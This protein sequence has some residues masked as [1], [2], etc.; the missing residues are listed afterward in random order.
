MAQ[1]LGMIRKLST[2]FFGL[3]I[4]AILIYFN[5]DRWHSFWLGG[6][7]FLVY[8]LVLGTYYRRVLTKF[9]NFLDKT[10]TVFVGAF[11]GLFIFAGLSGV[12][13]V[14][15]RLDAAVIAGA[16]F[17]SGALGSVS[18]EWAERARR[19][20]TEVSDLDDNIAKEQIPNVHF[21]ALVFLVLTAYGF[22]LLAH[23]VTG[24]AIDTPWWAIH[25]YFLYVFI[26]ATLIIG[27][28]VFSQLRAR[29]ILLLLIIYTFLLHSYLP[30]THEL[31]YG[32]DQWR[33]LAAES[34]IVQG[35][36]PGTVSIESADTP[37]FLS[38]TPGSLFYSQ[39][40]GL[41]VALGQVLQVDLIT[42]AK[43]LLPII[44][45]IIFP[46]LV[47][48]IGL[49][50]FLHKKLVLFLIWLTALP[51]ALTV[52]GSLT[53]PS[54]LGFLFWLLTIVLILSRL[55][56]KRYEQIIILSIL[57]IFSVFGYGLYLLL[58]IGAWILAEIL[59]AKFFIKHKKYLA[60]MLGVGV[61]VALPTV[62]LVVKYSE[63]GSRFGFWGGIKQF[64]GNFTAWYL[65]TGPRPHTIDTG[66]VF[67]NQVPAAAFVANFFNQ[68][69]W[70]L[71]I[72][73]STILLMGL[74]G[75]V[76]AL[77]SRDSRHQFFAFL[78]IALFGGYFV[79]RY[80]LSG[81]NIISRRLDAPLAF[82]IIVLVMLA[83]QTIWLK[84]FEKIQNWQRR[85]V[86]LICIAVLSIGVGVSYSLGPNLN[87]T[88]TDAWRAMK[89]VYEQTTMYVGAPCVLADTYPLLGLEYLSSKKIVGG[90]FPMGDN[91]SQVERVKLFESMKS[92][93]A[94]DIFVRAHGITGANICYFVVGS[95]EI[96]Y[97][98]YTYRESD[99]WKLFG[100]YIVW[101]NVK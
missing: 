59:S 40:W 20:H 53:L 16:I 9:F 65:A 94:A 85:T 68:D 63:W 82:L 98:G 74:V 95:K 78:F 3:A 42:I 92:D 55:K 44:W 19:A 76:V 91:F 38:S 25:P 96:K 79:C 56:E 41:S 81:A 24:T 46:L 29:T 2:E 5:I 30:L 12:G 22:Y 73:A 72:L 77:R 8:L 48:N 37:F 93:P 4:L 99:G 58:F 57:G 49:R 13:V 88:S 26:I 64:F 23:S 15:Y 90:G 18:H 35:L 70:W 67:F 43:W 28:L 60:W 61:A 7:L 87:T 83:A 80:L 50:I 47:Y 36:N 39:F 97:N 11:L 100:D 66:N 52:S 45:S 101:K 33:H 84:Y 51:F 17:I 6:F 10:T 69:L 27:V 21:G 32:A 31:F 34:R 75:L 62:E 54:N 86:L 1:Y 71:V 89:Y 14:F